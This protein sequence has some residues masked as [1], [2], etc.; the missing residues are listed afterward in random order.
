MAINPDC[1][2]A[3]FR[4]AGR[5][6]KER[7]IKEL[8]TEIEKRAAAAKQ[9]DPSLS[10]LDAQIK[11]ADQLAHD[12]KLA[13][14]IEKRNAVINQRK[15]AQLQ[16]YLSN[17]WGDRPADGM[18]AILTG[19]QRSRE[20]A[21]RSASLEQTA[22]SGKYLGGVVADIEKTGHSKL[23]ASGSIDQDIARALWQL[24]D[25][26]ADFA[27]LMPEAV[28]VA[29]AIKKWQE[30]SRLDANKEGANIGKETHYITRQSHDLHKI[31]KA[32]YEAWRDAILPKLDLARTVGTMGEKDLDTF[33]RKTYEGLASGVHLK[34]DTRPSM[35]G[36]K[37]PSNIAKR[38]SQERVLHFKSADD[39]FDYNNQFGTGSLRES[40]FSSLRKSAQST[41]LMRVLGTNP[42]NMIDILG[43]QTLDGISD[44]NAKRKFADAL[45]GPIANRLKQVDGTVNIPGNATAARVSANLRAWESM[46]KLG[47][48]VVSSLT[49]VPV[50]ASEVKFQGRGMLSGLHEAVSGLAAGRP[51]GERAQVLSSVGVVFDSMIGEITRQ[52]SL[53]ESFSAGVG[54]GLQ[55][56][57]KWNLL[58]WWTDSLRASTAM[59]LSHFLAKESVKAF[60][61]L[62][63]EMQ[64]MFKLYGI[65]GEKWNHIRNGK[66]MLADGREYL[67]PEGVEDEKLGDALR[68][69]YIDRAHTAVIEP[70][71]ETMAIMRQGTQSGTAYGEL[72]RFVGQFKSFGIAFTQKVLGREVYGY[73]SDSLGQALKDG[74]SL[75][76]L[77]NVIL[78]TTLFGYG[79]MAAKDLLKGKNPRSPTDAKTWVASAIQGGGFGIYGDFLLGQTDRFGGGLLGKVA[80]PVPGLIEDVDQIRARVMSGDDAAPTALRTAMNNTPFLNLFYT[81]MALDYMI[82]Y[83]V[84]ESMNPGY[85]RRME[86]RAQKENGQTFWLSPSEAVR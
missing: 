11:A 16:G 75:R 61:D 20:G 7:E 8:D 67:T 2:Q 65:D 59:G 44:P 36:F 12:M 24:D 41:G 47:G 31:R 58:N 3:I 4:E 17:T 53:D 43:R 15:Q 52:G 26:K 40:V 35:T 46:A 32:G 60:D 57:F 18:Q 81:R 37:G 22:L 6:L 78:M 84:Q 83:E 68:Q 64:R 56:M 66:Q 1:Y 14:L 29:K 13:T 76:G 77:A 62:A 85:L 42:T 45:K 49:D 69:F 38:A 30:V 23:F 5:D 21:R 39:W 28:D 19:V 79:A 73:G 74:Q 10:N 51:K 34:A 9:I 33:L 82:L 50:Y 48:A 70:D 71:A 80:G 55:T 86:K 25:E 63:P 54:R 72:L 27:G